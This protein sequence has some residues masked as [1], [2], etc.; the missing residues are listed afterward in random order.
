MEAW[1]DNSK[2]KTKTKQQ[3]PNKIQ[4]IALTQ[5]MTIW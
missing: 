4:T 1:E 5:D 2:K 3:K